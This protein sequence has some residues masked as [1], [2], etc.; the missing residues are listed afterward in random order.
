MILVG[1]L[2]SNRQTVFFL[3]VDPTD[4][5]YGDLEKV[6]LKAPCFARHLH[7]VWKKL[8]ITVCIWVDIRL[9]QK[10]G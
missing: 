6:D 3:L 9:A 1:Q 4:K 8:Q 5:N 2:W 7:Q 10:E